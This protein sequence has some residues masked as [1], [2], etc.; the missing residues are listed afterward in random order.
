M[1]ELITKIATSIEKLAN[2]IGEMEARLDQIE[3]GKNPRAT[4]RATRKAKAE[5]E[6]AEESK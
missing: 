1:E 6:P 5:P 3:T 2:K 4:P